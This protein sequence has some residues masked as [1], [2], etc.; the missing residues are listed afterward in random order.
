VVASPAIQQISVKASVETIWGIDYPSFNAL[1]PFIFLSGSP[2]EGPNDVI[3]DDIFARTG[4]HYAVGDTIQVLDHPFRISGIVEH[5]KGARKFLP[6]RSLGAL[7][8]AE[9]NASLIFLKS[10]DPKNEKLI[11]QEIHAQPGMS[12]YQVETVAEA[13][14]QMTPEHLPAFNDALHVVI[15]LAVVVGFLVIFQSMYTAVLERTREIG[16]LKSLGASQFYVVNLVLRETGFLA[17]VGIAVGIGFTFALKAVMDNRFPTLPFPISP[18][19]IMYATL[20]AFGGALVG[21]SY[22]ALKAAQKDP[23]EALAYE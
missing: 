6:I 2:F 5:G 16:I 17:I 8:G 12:E 4:K 13:L 20:I 19:W 9:N 3:V 18:G 21:A 11:E 10:D 14:S 22:P 23:I 1:R 7:L 15:G